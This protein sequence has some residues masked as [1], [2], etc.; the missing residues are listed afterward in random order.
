M[1]KASG[2]GRCGANGASL[3]HGEKNVPHG[4]N[5]LRKKAGFGAELAKSISQGLKPA[6]ILSILNQG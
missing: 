3:Q 5:R 1:R 6:L 4:L 2:D